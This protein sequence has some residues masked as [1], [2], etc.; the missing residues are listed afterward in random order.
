MVK[1]IV[2]FKFKDD[3]KADDRQVIMST[4]KK[5][6][7]SLKNIIKCIKDINVG[8]NINDEEQWDICLE[9]T[10]DT[11][12]DVRFYSKHPQHVIAAG[13]LKPHLCGRSC[14]D[15]EI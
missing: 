6:I 14:V 15:F 5:D 13:K 7:L 10:F 9:S 3:I 12:E 1:H 11:L 4:F 8:F 2:L